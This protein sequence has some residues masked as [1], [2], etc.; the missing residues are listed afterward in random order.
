ML[1]ILIISKDLDTV[2]RDSSVRAT[3]IQKSQVKW[4]PYALDPALPKEGVDKLT[5]Y[6]KKFGGIVML[7]R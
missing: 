6:N 3:H 1:A 4:H 5:R 2:L 7:L